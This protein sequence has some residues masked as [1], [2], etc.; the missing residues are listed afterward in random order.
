[1]GSYKN[2][3]V[4]S[5]AHA[6]WLAHADETKILRQLEYFD[7]YM[8][9]LD[10]IYLEPHRGE[11]HVPAEKL[12]RFIELFKAR[13]ITVA[14]GLTATTD[15]DDATVH[16]IFDV[17]C[18]SRDNFREE[19]KAVVQET[20][21]YFDEFILDDFFFT[22]CRCSECIKKK[23]SRTWSQYRLELMEEISHLVCDTA[24]A[25]NPNCRCVI[26]YPNWFE[27]W[28]E[29]GYNPQKQKDIFDAIYTAAE[30]R[31]PK[32]SQQHLPRYLSY[33]LPRFLENTAPGKNNGAWV[34]NG[35][36][37]NN[38]NWYTEQVSLAVLAGAKEVCL[39]GFGGLMDAPWLPAL[40]AQLSL[41][42][43]NKDKLGAPVG[44]STYYPFNADCGEDQLYNYVGM[45]GIPLE[46]TP[47]FDDQAQTLFLT[48]AAAQDP[49]VVDRLKTYV[50]KGGH[51][52][53]TSGFVNATKDRGIYDMTSARVTTKIA[54]GS[55]YCTDPY[56]GDRREFFHG[57]ADITVH[58]IDYKTNATWSDCELISENCNYPMWLRDDYGMGELDIFNIPDNYSDLYKLP[59]AVM[60]L[61]RKN[62]ARHTQAYIEALSQYNLFLYDNDTFVIASY[63]EY[64]EYMN[65]VVRGACSQ[66]VELDSG[67]VYEPVRVKDQPDQRFDVAYVPESARESVFEIYF[68][69]GTFKYFQIIK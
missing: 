48:A 43:A 7:T 8:G 51:A 36:A 61:I 32:M 6:P 62:F 23:G 49:Q 14:G 65:V 69:P 42:D 59:E 60:T 11:H 13:G 63:R 5:Y 50:E 44:V 16:R 29:T 21:K 68:S 15:L 67:K 25:V 58:G 30:S 20:A 54:T 1:M 47:W 53:V 28:Q 66:I 2:F 56:I 57:P 19:F 38:L 45:L 27:A 3:T 64:R 24:K 34:D 35:D 18:F 10:K 52:I 55:F 41:L 37:S 4:A 26:K 31:N 39:F 33:S 17:Y 46:P 9:G 12:E 40:G 22:S